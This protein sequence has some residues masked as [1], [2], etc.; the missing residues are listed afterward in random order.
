MTNVYPKADFKLSR[1]SL[2]NFC[3]KYVARGNRNGHEIK[4]LIGENS[5]FW[6]EGYF[7]Y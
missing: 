2:W 7:I 5:F 4:K 6:G 3:R 1:Y